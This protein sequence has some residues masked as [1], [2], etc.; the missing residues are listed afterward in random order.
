MILLTVNHVEHG[1]SQ[2]K[3]D[4]TQSCRKYM[5][6]SLY[7]VATSTSLLTLYSMV[8][9]IIYQYD[10]AGTKLQYIVCISVKFCSIYQF[11]NQLANIK[12][13]CMYDYEIDDAKSCC[14]LIMR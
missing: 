10:L 2:C 11:S 9:H 8:Y 1:M 3:N 6:Q 7:T 12:F 4:Y 14:M 13:C 5:H